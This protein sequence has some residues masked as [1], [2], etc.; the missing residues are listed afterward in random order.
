MRLSKE[1]RTGLIITVGIVLLFW[2]LNYLKGKD[3]FTSQKLVYAI[4]PQVDG[5][6]TSNPVQVN[7]LKIGLIRSLTLLTEQNG[8]V[9]VSMHINKKV[10]IPANSIAEIFSTDLLG[11]KGIR[12]V[13]GNSANELQDGDTLIS[14]IQKSL[15]EEVSAQVAPIKLKAESILLS[16]DS[17]LLVLREVFNENTKNSLRRS[18]ESISNSLLSIEHITSSMDTVMA[19]EGRLKVIFENLESITTNIKE[20]NE[21]ITTMIENFAAISD[22]IARSH[23]SETLENTKKTLEQT[24]GIMS[25][26]N[27][28]E[29][30]LGQLANNDS[31]Y[32]NLTATAHSLD[33]LL[34]D[35][36]NNPRKYL[37][38]S[39]ISF[40][41]KR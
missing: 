15:P 22:T 37:N 17:V 13:M 16:L 8:K 14:N 26:V 6:L 38:V 24:S 23:I 11:S 12:I 5:L 25:K 40:G 10:H 30:T 29:G 39:L 28:G 21:K 27:S 19:K 1:A 7:G 31:L 33:L 9:L 35:F 41:K 4:Y 20:N 3:F 2:G 18:F 34:N 36:R 32:N